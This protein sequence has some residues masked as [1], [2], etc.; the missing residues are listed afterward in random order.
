MV[1]EIGCFNLYIRAFPS[2]RDQILVAHAAP[3]HLPLGPVGTKYARPQRRGARQFDGMGRANIASLRDE[4]GCARGGVSTDIT[5][6]RDENRCARYS[7][8][9]DIWSLRDEERRV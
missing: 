5:S 3:P 4:D 1:E 2:R 7:F 9:T 6:L 8:S